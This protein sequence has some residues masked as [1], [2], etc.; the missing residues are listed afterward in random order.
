MQIRNRHDLLTST[1]F[2]YKVLKFFDIS[3]GVVVLKPLHRTGMEVLIHSE[4]L[5]SFP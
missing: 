2:N 3:R 4:A 5:L 1:E